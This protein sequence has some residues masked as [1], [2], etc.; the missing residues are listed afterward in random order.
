SGEM[1][2]DDRR[3]VLAR[4]AAGDLDVVANCAVLTEGYDNPAVS[5]VV[6]AR[7]TKS[8]ALYVQMVGR[9]T[10]LHPDKA[11]ALVLD[12]VGASAEHNLVTAPSLFGLDATAA[13][14][15]SVLLGD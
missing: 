13:R 4:F 9:G 10:R 1:P 6:V 11:D 2:L 5:C 7:P 14:D 8:R 12:V 3:A 15:G